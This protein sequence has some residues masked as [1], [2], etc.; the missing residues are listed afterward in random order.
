MNDELTELQEQL[1]QILMKMDKTLKDE[2]L[3]PSIYTGVKDFYEQKY[4]ND[5]MNIQND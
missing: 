1:D 5:A 3:I 2:V 4:A